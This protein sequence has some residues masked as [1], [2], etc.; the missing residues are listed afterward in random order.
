[1]KAV[2]VKGQGVRGLKKT[3]SRSLNALSKT[4]QGALVEQLGS[5]EKLTG[6]DIILRAMTT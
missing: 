1:M 5:A 4:L 6:I 2:V 3:F